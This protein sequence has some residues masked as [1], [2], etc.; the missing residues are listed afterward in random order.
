[1][2]DAVTSQEH[3]SGRVKHVATFTSI[4]DGTGENAVKKVDISEL[5]GAPEKVK[6]NKVQYSISGMAV[7]I[8]FNHSSPDTVLVL[9]GIGVLDFTSF[10]GMQDPASSGGTGDIQFTTAGHA[11]S[12]TYTITLEVGI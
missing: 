8:A 7:E 11:A 1:M 2:S 10:G 9:S 4:S 5:V 6:I 12:D 3:F